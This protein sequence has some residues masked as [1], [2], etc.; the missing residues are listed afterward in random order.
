LIHALGGL[1]SVFGQFTTCY[2][3]KCTIFAFAKS[4]FFSDRRNGET[5]DKIGGFLGNIFNK[6]STTF[7]E[8]EDDEYNL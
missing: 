3:G 4:Q 8:A 1:Y 6:V 2:K 7:S 5:P